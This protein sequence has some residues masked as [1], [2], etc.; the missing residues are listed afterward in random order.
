MTITVLNYARFKV[1]DLSLNIH[2]RHDDHGIACISLVTG[3][4]ESIAL[5]V[6]KLEMKSLNHFCHGGVSYLYVITRFKQLYMK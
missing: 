5:G 1:T 2:R 3:M 4:T 6:A